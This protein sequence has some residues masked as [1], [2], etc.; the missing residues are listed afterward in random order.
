MDALHC[1]KTRRSIRVYQ[2]RSIPKEVLMDI[3]DCARMSPSA[4]NKQPW[5]FIVI[6]DPLLLRQ[7]AELTDYGK[8]I[9]DAPACIAVFCQQTRYYLEDG[10][11]ATMAILL[12]AWAHGVGSCWVAGDK[13]E[14]ADPI[15]RLL[16]VPD[17]Y[18]LV[19]LVPL[20]YPAEQPEKEKRPLERV[21]HWNTFQ[22]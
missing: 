8:F 16:K 21:L 10:S 2:K 17:G 13:K 19:S 6:T 5:E 22:S 20:G 3:V 18:R 4:V 7:V 11:A 1:L 14:Y 9:A 12:A 15:R